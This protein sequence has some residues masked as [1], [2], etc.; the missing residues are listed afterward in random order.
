MC[1]MREVCDRLGIA[2]ETLRF[3]CKE[4]LVPGV[5]R[6]KSNYRDFDE[7]NIRWI[8]SLQCLRRCGMGIEDMKRYMELCLQGP[9]SVPER[10]EML[11]LQ[12]EQ[13]L[14]EMDRINESM[15][16]IDN[17]QA[18]YDGVLSGDVAYTSNL[19]RVDEDDDES[20]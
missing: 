18:F 3:Y 11:A 9:S 4:G 13:L 8:K 6:N 17:K 10:K 12:K 15:A 7:R 2:Y 19:I 16:Y 20:A 5:K 14:A 1:T